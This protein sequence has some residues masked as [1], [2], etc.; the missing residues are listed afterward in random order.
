MKLFSLNL[1]LILF[2]TTFFSQE[3][4]ISFPKGIY[5]SFEDFKVMKP[6]DSITQFSIRVGNDTISNRFYNTKTFKRMRKEFAFSD[7][8]FLYVN[9]KGIMKNF[10][11]EDKGQLKDD[12][13]YHLK[14][15]LI[16]QKYIYFEDYFTSTEA[17]IFGGLIGASAAR[18]LKGVL[19]NYETNKFNLFK[20]AEDFENFV[21]TY[22]PQ[23][24]SLLESTEIKYK[25]TKRKKRVEDIEIIRKVIL[26][27]YEMNNPSTIIK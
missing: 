11:K 26:D 2:T 3:K 5:K 13:N 25:S 15:I 4:T 6:S 16:G 22:H 23:Y 1:L 17:A 7:G 21:T 12:G 14:A 8:D 19:Y 24:L 9:V 10:L 27:V 18:R 20:N